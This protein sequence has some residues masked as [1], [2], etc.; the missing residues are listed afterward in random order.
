MFS[1]FQDVYSGPIDERLFPYYKH[2]ETT[3]ELLVGASESC[4]HFYIGDLEKALTALSAAKLVINEPG[5]KRD[6]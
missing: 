4:K 6:K 1:D 2:L 3:A 5:D